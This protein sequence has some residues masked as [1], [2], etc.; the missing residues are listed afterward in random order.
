LAPFGD[1]SVVCVEQCKI[2]WPESI[3]SPWLIDERRAR[4][5]DSL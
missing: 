3:G 5:V 4:E 1:S 2:E